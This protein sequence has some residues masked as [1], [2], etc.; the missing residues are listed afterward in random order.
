[1]NRRALLAAGAALAA[2]RPFAAFASPLKS[3]S[4]EDMTRY[5]AFAW[6][7]LS[8]LSAELGVD[9]CD[10]YTGYRNGDSEALRRALTAPPSTRCLAVLD[11]AEVGLDRIGSRPYRHP[12]ITILEGRA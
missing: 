12:S 10:S 9:M 3:P 7:E 4:F 2:L 5:Y 1:M 6:F 11:A 8:A